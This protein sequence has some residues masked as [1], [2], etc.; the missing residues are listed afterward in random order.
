M[1]QRANGLQSTALNS[2][3]GPA[4]WGAQLP[5]LAA[6]NRVRVVPGGAVPRTQTKRPV[7]ATPCQAQPIEPA[8][9]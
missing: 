3:F 1:D 2:G 9:Y 8:L 5:Q 4:K 7:L 6:A